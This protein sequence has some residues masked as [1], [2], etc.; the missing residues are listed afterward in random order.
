MIGCLPTFK[1]PI[2]IFLP[3]NVMLLVKH[4]EVDVYFDMQQVNSVVRL[5]VMGRCRSKG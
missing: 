1:A 5:K 2:H 4:T 3:K